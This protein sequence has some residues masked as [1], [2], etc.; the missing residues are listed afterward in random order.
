MPKT[1]KEPDDPGPQSMFLPRARMEPRWA[2]DQLDGLR[3]ALVLI[4]QQVDMPENDDRTIKTF[5]GGT[6]MDRAR[7]TV[8]DLDASI[9]KKKP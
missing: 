6:L 1:A 4:I 7:Q 8:I 3:R 9:A 5:R 2:A